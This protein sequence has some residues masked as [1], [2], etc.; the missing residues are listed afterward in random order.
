MSDINN[1][2]DLACITR[3]L[4]RQHVLTLCAGSGMDIWCANCFY[5]F[6][7]AQMAVYLMT[8][9]HTRHGELMQKNPQVVGTIATAPRTIALIKGIQYR[10]N[11]TELTG[12]AAQVARQRYCRRFPVAKAASAP[13]WQITLLEIKMTNNTLGFGKKLYWQQSPSSLMPQGC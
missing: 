10:G 4:R 1:P 13:L 6:D 9:K 11:I 12:E 2:D 3:F 5:V 7:E 8:E